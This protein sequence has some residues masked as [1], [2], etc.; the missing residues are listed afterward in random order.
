MFEPDRVTTHTHS[1]YHKATKRYFGNLLSKK[2][3]KKF[4]SK[5]F[6][7]VILMIKTGLCPLIVTPK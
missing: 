7:V 4:Y 3:V 1:R 5:K 6:I 2:V